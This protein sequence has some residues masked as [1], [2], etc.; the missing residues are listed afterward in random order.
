MKKIILTAVF[1]SVIIQSSCSDESHEPQSPELPSEITATIQILFHDGDAGRFSVAEK[2]TITNILVESETRVRE[3]LRN[4]PKVI[5]VSVVIIDR[6]IDVVGGVTGRADAPGVVVFELSSVFPG[7]ISAAAQSALSSAIFHEFHHLDRGWTIQ[8]NKFGAGIPIAAVNEGL[9]SVFSEEYTGVYFEAAY[10]YPENAVEW[11]EEILALPEDADYST[12]MMG[13]H[14]DGRNSIGYRV[15][16]YVI[17]QATANSG[18]NVLELSQLQP[19][20][21]LELAAKAAH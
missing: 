10:S 18:M 17:H 21:I 8:G 5:D 19:D 9:A 13:E 1:V 14:P 11:L 16:R 12:W 6:D 3:L 7:G 2:E 20:K 15:G 4:L